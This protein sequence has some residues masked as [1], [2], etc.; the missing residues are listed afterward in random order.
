LNNGT[1]PRKPIAQALA[2]SG[3]APLT[4]TGITVFQINVGKLCNQT[5]GH[6]HVDAGPDRREIMTR[7]VAELCIE[8]LR[9]SAI[10]T[11]DITGGAPELNPN[12]RWLVEQSRMLGRHVIDRCNL[13]VLL[14]PSQAGLAEFLA[15]QQVEI[16]ASLP[17]YL[18]P[19]TDAQ[20]GAG[21]FA[22][23]V[24]ALRKLNALGYGHEGSG[25]RLTL[26]Y[27]PAGA[28]LPPAERAIEADFKREL[29]RRHGIVFNSLYTITNMP[30]SRFLDFLLR[31]GNYDR[32][33]DKLVHAYNPAAAA[34][35]MCRYT[36]SV[37]WD[38]TLYDCDFNQMLE[39]PVAFGAPAHIRDFKAGRL[40]RRQITVGQHCYGCTAGSGSSCGGATTQGGRDA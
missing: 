25:L 16:V 18:E 22:K 31:S 34:S 10:A 35:V 33:M 6:C 1:G 36:L 28:F 12:F 19:Q 23:S 21:V 14:L 26:V 32:Y 40:D 37:G 11:V 38:G 24:E 3:L 27:N 20:R 15:A 5:C 9:G 2:E 39:M 7:E 29:A 13:S 30:I 8:A 4:A 17:Y